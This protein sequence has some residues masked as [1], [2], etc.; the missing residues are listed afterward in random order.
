MAESK[1]ALYDS[2]SIFETIKLLDAQLASSTTSKSR[3]DKKRKFDEKSME[4]EDA[5]KTP[6]SGKD[7]ME[8]VKSKNRAFGR[9]IGVAFAEG[10]IAARTVGVQNLFDLK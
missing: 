4:F 6:I 8:F 3:I 5:L 10:F 9:P 1:R 7:F 2:S